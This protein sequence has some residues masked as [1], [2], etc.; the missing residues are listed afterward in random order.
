MHRVVAINLALT[1]ALVLATI[2]TRLVKLNA[3]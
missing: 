3:I 1:Y 2:I